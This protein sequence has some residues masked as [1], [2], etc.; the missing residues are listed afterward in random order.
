M[1]EK[2]CTFCKQIIKLG[3]AYAAPS[4]GKW[5]SCQDC[6]LTK[7]KA[8]QA[9]LAAQTARVEELEKAINQVLKHIATHQVYDKNSEALLRLALGMETK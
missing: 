8:V 1:S 7:A 9:Q 2:Q 5:V 6:I 4:D 3:E